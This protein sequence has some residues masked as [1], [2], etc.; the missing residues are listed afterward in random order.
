VLYLGGLLLFL[1][2]VGHPI[3]KANWTRNGTQ[4]M[5]QDLDFGE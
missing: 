3:I 4:R 5:C 2:L 1:H